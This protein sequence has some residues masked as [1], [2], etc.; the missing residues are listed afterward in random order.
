MQLPKIE[1]IIDGITYDNTF[2]DDVRI[3]RTNIEEELVTQAE[4]YAYYAFLAATARAKAAYGKMDRDQTYARVDHEKRNVAKA[5]PGFKQTEKMVENEV[6]TDA[7]FIEA[8]KKYLDLNLLADQLEKAERAMA[9]RREM[10]IQLG[11]ITRQ[12]MSPMRVVEQNAVT[13]RDLIA[14]SRM[15]QEAPA[16]TMPDPVEPHEISAAPTQRRRR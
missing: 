13:A 2:S 15:Q 12:Q 6:I 10:L 1:I 9:Q 5:I 4:K 11:G 16:P 7:R 14:Q 3:D 8:E